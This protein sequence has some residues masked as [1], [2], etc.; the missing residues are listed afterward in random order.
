MINLA[1][2]R[3]PDC[4]VKGTD[5]HLLNIADMKKKALCD[6]KDNS[7]IDLDAPTDGSPDSKR[8]E[9]ES[10]LM[11]T[12]VRTTIRAY[13]I[14]QYMRGVFINSVF[15][16]PEQMSEDTVNYV[17]SEIKN[18]LFEYDSLPAPFPQGTYRDDF[19]EALTELYEAEKEDEEGAEQDYEDEHHAEDD[20]EHF[21]DDKPDSDEAL[22]H[23]IRIEYPDVAAKLKQI[24]NVSKPDS[25][26]DIHNVFIEEYLPLFEIPSTYTEP[27]FATSEIIGPGSALAN[28]FAELDES[29]EETGIVQSIQRSSLE[30]EDGYGFDLED[31]VF[32]D[33]A[34]D[35]TFAESD[36]AEADYEFGSVS[37]SEATL[38]DFLKFNQIVTE[39]EMGGISNSFFGDKMAK[40]FDS[41][42]GQFYF[43]PYVRVVDHPIDVWKELVEWGSGTGGDGSY[44]FN[45]GHLD[46][47]GSADEPPVEYWHHHGVMSEETFKE[48]ISATKQ[49]LADFTKYNSKPL[50]GEGGLFAEVHH[51][52]RIM[53]LPPTDT[54]E[55]VVTSAGTDY[56]DWVQAIN[57][58]R[59]TFGGFP[60]DLK[61]ITNTANNASKRK[62]ISEKA[63]RVI[64]H[65]EGISAENLEGFVN[66]TRVHFSREI[67][68]FP[69]ASAEKFWEYASSLTVEEYSTPGTFIVK[70]SHSTMLSELKNTSEYKLLTEYIF[71]LDRYKTLMSLYGSQAIS[72][73]GNVAI[74]YAET[75]DELYRLFHAVNAKGDYKQ[76][77]KALEKIGGNEGLAQTVNNQ[78]GGIQDIPCLDFSIGF[79]FSFGL[80]GLG[81]SFILKM[82]I[83]AA[84]IMFKKW[85][86]RFD[87]NISLAFALS[88]LS[89]LVCLNIPTTAFSFGL[90]PMNVFIGL[91]GIPISPQGFI[92]HALGMGLW[93]SVGDDNSDLKKQLKDLGFEPAAL[94]CPDQPSDACGLQPAGP[95]SGI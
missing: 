92:Y 37:G 64:E 5:P 90:L 52:Y 78:F 54:S 55:F 63:Y 86:E 4:I 35:A 84:L 53:Y 47:I 38:N 49:K 89:K 19:M 25:E 95:A 62:I 57:D 39:V 58:R 20:G 43:E 40:P 15:G 74:A 29:A 21:H 68:P 11:K 72:T 22:K 14:D 17:A 59:Q 13:V 51:G 32:V 7:C 44:M 61:D 65:F 12:V 93:K 8:S 91:P 36:L 56:N 69:V 23:Y 75:K 31:E 67:N 41:T 6:I 80:K 3:S 77:D 16:E 42:N 46:F 81:L 34:G 70:P 60:V 76:H 18:G 85:V 33:A 27:R 83:E 10:A 87:L 71:P 94:P 73:T 48:L 1:P 82:V 45:R 88:F 26:K 30:G 24:F 66:A 2:E 79:D 50:V 9:M 28:K